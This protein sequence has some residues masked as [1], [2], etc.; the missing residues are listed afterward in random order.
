MQDIL[1]FGLYSVLDGSIHGRNGG[2][3]RA[4][5][6]YDQP[7]ATTWHGPRNLTSLECFEDLWKN[8]CGMDSVPQ[9][10]RAPWFWACLSEPRE[11]MVLFHKGRTPHQGMQGQNCV[12]SIPESQWRPFLLWGTISFVS[13]FVSS[14]VHSFIHSTHIHSVRAPCQASCWAQDHRGIQPSFCSGEPHSPWRM[15]LGPRNLG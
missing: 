8:S 11:A 7:R 10:D 12:L 2:R 14:S 9:K 6:L 13:S 3:V 1:R 5:L 15:Y 4:R